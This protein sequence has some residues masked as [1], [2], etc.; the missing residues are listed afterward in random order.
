[1]SEYFFLRWIGKILALK[2]TIIMLK[3]SKFTLNLAREAFPWGNR[4]EY[5]Q[6]PP[7]H[8]DGIVLK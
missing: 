3:K 1:M 7:C 6:G 2:K 5:T 8:H 4:W